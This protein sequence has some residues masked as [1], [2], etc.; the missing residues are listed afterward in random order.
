VK[1]LGESGTPLL[2]V[3]EKLY[4]FKSFK[5]ILKIQN[6][7]M[8]I[9]STY[10][11][12]SEM[13][14]YEQYSTVLA[15]ALDKITRELIKTLKLVARIT[16]TKECPKLLKKAKANLLKERKIDS[17]MAPARAEALYVALG[18]VC[19]VPNNLKK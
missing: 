4:L 12:P 3:L 16:F 1:D 8:N 11:G 7:Y 5:I 13:I 18:T 14:T 17:F 6:A 19:N 10:G 9:W 15:P 2:L